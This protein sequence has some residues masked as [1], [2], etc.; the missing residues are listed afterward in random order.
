MRLPKRLELGALYELL[1]VSR[2]EMP[3]EVARVLGRE[4]KCN[5][6]ARRLLLDLAHGR[7]GHSPK[8]IVPALVELIAVDPDT[9]IGFLNSGDVE[10]QAAGVA[11]GRT[12]VLFKGDLKATAE[13]SSASSRLAAL[14]GFSEA[15]SSGLL[16]ATDELGRLLADPS[17]QVRW[18]AAAQLGTVREPSCVGR[19]LILLSQVVDTEDEHLL[20]G[21]TTGLIRLYER[22]PRRV[23]RVLLYITQSSRAGRRATA[24]SL[25]HLA[26][27]ALPKIVELCLSDQ[28][29]Y[30]RAT[31]AVALD[32]WAE[33]EETQRRKLRKLTGDGA[34]SVRAAA[35]E[36]LAAAS[37]SEDSLVA[38]LA[39]D[40]SVIVRK[41]V[42]EG[43]SRNPISNRHEIARMLAGDEAGAVRAAAVACLMLGEED[44]LIDELRRDSSPVVRAAVA[45]SL[46]RW[47]AA[48]EGWLVD[49]SR[50]RDGFVVRAAAESLGGVVPDFCGNGWKRLLELAAQRTTADAAAMGIAVALDRY[51][52][53]VM[54]LV[55]NWP[56][57]VAT[58]E[59]FLTVARSATDWR[60]S[61]VSRSMLRILGGDDDDLRTGLE[62]AAQA[63]EA[64][65]KAKLSASL[66]WLVKCAAADPFKIPTSLGSLAPSDFEAIA[67]LTALVRALTEAARRGR[68][69]NLRDSQT[70]GS[71]HAIVEESAD[72][73]MWHI[74][75][76]I[77]L[78]W[79]R[80]IG[81]LDTG[82]SRLRA[83]LISKN[84]ICGGGGSL[85]VGVEN[86][87]DKVVTVLRLE[88]QAQRATTV[89][90][91]LRP[92]ERW[93]F[94]VPFSVEEDGITMV[95][96]ELSFRS[97]EADGTCEVVGMVRAIRPGS[98]VPVAN[99][100]VV[101]KPLP[102]S[103]DMF[104]GREEDIEFVERALASGDTGTVAVI[105]GA[106]R[107]GKTSLLKRLEFRLST[108]YQTIFVDMQ[109][110]LVSDITDFFRELV[111]PVTSR[112]DVAARV[113]RSVW[114]DLHGADMVREVAESSDRPMVL[115]LDE[116]DDLDQKVRDGLIS[117]E[118][119]DQLRNLIQHT[120]NLRL[121]LSG[122]HRL[123]QIAGDQW[124][125]LLNMATYRRLG[126]LSAL[127][128]EDVLLE[129]LR[130]L[131]IICEDAAVARATRLTGGHPYLLQLLG[132]RTVEGCVASGETCAH[133]GA[134]ERATEQVVEQGD[135]HLR[136]LWE[137]TGAEGQ[138][139]LG[140]LADDEYGLDELELRKRVSLEEGALSE[141]LT[142]LE[143][144]DVIVC[145][146]GRYALRIGLLARWLKG[147]RH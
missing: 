90:V 87:G 57:S 113:D 7:L 41:A 118:V 45:V 67:G 37:W 27:S 85:L 91:H 117:K 60:V 83:T 46:S 134:V 10:G 88:I 119:F 18:R 14:E 84:V 131:G 106:R 105:V 101:G 56:L 70:L 78:M 102:A 36:A 122:T 138:K 92:G 25:R 64:A 66:T 52:D 128:S 97:G 34:A 54:D 13:A 71:L 129:P 135:I 39:V 74:V 61:E 140:A 104:F 95:R 133:A 146:Q 40:P 24:L 144:Y 147:A 19:A 62:D 5:N 111:R 30:V 29:P 96:G 43:L 4:A 89:D 116:F 73:V 28:S 109:G 44:D 82:N 121:V 125:F 99:P 141:A 107:T 126:C 23:G 49:L 12:Y 132:Y 22:A 139:V 79:Q 21:A 103:S 9:V 114:K 145:N 38:E 112:Y 15:A 142:V 130:R 17:P 8:F 53:K 110:I 51:G 16:D 58:L 69:W 98:L 76:R 50:D 77:A 94:V 6:W 65:G 108:S 72:T 75:R 93:Q 59:C 33:R 47:G 63:S 1:Y 11:L 55:W 80:K 35:A 137:S 115:L 32:R 31:C 42:A 123:E 48:M 20:S 143:S 124:S 68:M 2:R 26:R 127:E 86:T 100:Y 136:Y 3:S 120:K 81:E